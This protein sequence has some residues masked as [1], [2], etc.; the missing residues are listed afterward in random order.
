[1]NKPRQLISTQLAT[2]V[3]DTKELERQ[4]DNLAKQI[5]QANNLIV[6]IEKAFETMGVE[7][8]WYEN[9][10]PNGILLH[11]IKNYLYS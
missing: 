11:K 5:L 9:D 4:N 8:D 3:A 7:E 2:L 1:M 10:D 6:L